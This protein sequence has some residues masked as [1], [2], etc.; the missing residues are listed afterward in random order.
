M[1]ENFNILFHKTDK[2][3]KLLEVISDISSGRLPQKDVLT[4]K[5]V[6]EYSG[7]SNSTLYHESSHGLITSSR[8]GKKLF[9]PI[10]PFIDWYI[11]SYFQNS[12]RRKRMDE[13]FRL[14]K[15]SKTARLEEQKNYTSVG[16]DVSQV[17]K[18]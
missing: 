5:E 15:S 1:T 12:V 3:S 16:F 18:S 4:I 13:A 10:I 14:E 9:F 2:I 8:K 7:L 6:S 17:I 11:E